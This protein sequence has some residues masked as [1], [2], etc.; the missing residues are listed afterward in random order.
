MLHKFSSQSK[1]LN[2]QK[3]VKCKKVIKHTVNIR[4][5]RVEI[6]KTILSNTGSI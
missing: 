3:C 2:Q 5:P 4:S 6:R 1:Y